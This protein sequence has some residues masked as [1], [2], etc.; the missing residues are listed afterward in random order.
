MTRQPETSV[1]LGDLL[2][3]MHRADAGFTSVYA[4][5]RIWRHDQRMSEAVRAETQQLKRRGGSI[6]TF[7]SKG[8][9]SARGE[10]E[11]LLRVWRS[12]DRVRAERESGTGNAA[13][14]VRAGNLWW[15]WDERNGASSNEDD[16]TLASSIGEEL[17]VVLNPTPL[18]GVLKFTAVGRSEVAGRETITA[19]AAPRPP[20]SHRSSRSVELQQLG[21]GADRYALQVDA[22][23]GVL[24]EVVALRGGEPFHRITA[25]EI[26]FDQPIQDERFRFDPPAGE[27]IRPVKRRPQPERLSVPEAQ[28]RAPFTVM[29]PSR[30]PKGWHVNCVFVEASERP[31]WPAQVSINYSSDDAAESVSLMQASARER[32]GGWV[33]QLTTGKNWGQ[34]VKDGT[35]VD[36]TKSDERGPQVQAH[37]ERNGTFV[38]LMS[39]TLDIDEL[40]TLAAGLKPAPSMSTI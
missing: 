35:L 31:P 24:L 30:M 12:A 14:G 29:I 21:C 9:A 1:Q 2:L 37:L 17:A 16:P 20:D 5:Y 23:T 4:S 28:K 18:L 19:K 33:E 8:G 38:F 32:P 25:L 36:V 11:D 27:E 39:E 15:S 6:A 3:L 13:F 10:H 26:V 7:Q 40:A 34:L 22:K